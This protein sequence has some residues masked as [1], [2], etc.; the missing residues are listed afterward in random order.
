MPPNDIAIEV[1]FVGSDILLSFTRAACSPAAI[2]EFLVP[3]IQLHLQIHVGWVSKSAA[4]D[5]S[6]III[7]PPSSESHL[8]VGHLITE[9][10]V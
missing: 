5:L 3:A 8:A 9:P 4:I 7:D 2:K 10:I 6:K 1:R